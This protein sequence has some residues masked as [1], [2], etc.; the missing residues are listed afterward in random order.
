MLLQERYS[1]AAVGEAA[2]S[3]E[4]LAQLTADHFEVVILV[5]ELS[6]QPPEDLLPALHRLSERP[7]VIVLSGRPEL[8]PRARA[9][10][11]DAFVSM[12]DPPQRLLATLQAIDDDNLSEA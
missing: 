6:G 11:A 1:L 10:G 12:C 4:L 9:A 5:W 7:S 3:A 8:E 2:D